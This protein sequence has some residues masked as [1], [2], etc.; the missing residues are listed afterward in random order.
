MTDDDRVLIPFLDVDVASTSLL[1]AAGR[2][3]ANPPKLFP[4]G[5][6]LAVWIDPDERCE[7]HWRETLPTP[8]KSLW[9]DLVFLRT[10][11]GSL[12]ADPSTR[13]WCCPYE[14][15]ESL[16]LASYGIEE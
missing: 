8:E 2:L 7:P 13:V 15:L 3:L 6:P 12:R 1:T 11:V 4:L 9:G 10:I 5:T 14:E 16:R